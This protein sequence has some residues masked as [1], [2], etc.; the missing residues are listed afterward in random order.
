MASATG[1]LEMAQARLEMALGTL[2]RSVQGAMGAI[3]IGALLQVILRKGRPGIGA[4]YWV[5]K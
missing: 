4:T 5:I 1:H 3:L 2:G